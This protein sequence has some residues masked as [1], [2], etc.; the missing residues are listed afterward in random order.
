MLGGLTSAVSDTALILGLAGVGGT[1]IGTALGAAVAARSALSVERRR[2]QRNERTENDRLRAAARLVWLDLAQADGNLA[3]CI[4][5]NS[6]SPAKG[7]IP[8]TAWEQ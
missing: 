1:I 4:A 2:E 5:L 8:L 7:R 3:R 6:W